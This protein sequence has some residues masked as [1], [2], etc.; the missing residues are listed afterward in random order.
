MRRL[1]FPPQYHAH[2][3]LP[4]NYA[5]KY[6]TQH[7]TQLTTNQPM[8]T[9]SGFTLFEVSISLAIVSFSVISVIMLL[10]GGLKSQ[11]MARYQIIASAKAME[12]VE[13]FNATHNA[14]PTVEVEADQPWNVH[15]N[16]KV[17]Q[18][19][20]ESKISTFRFGTYPVPLDIARRLDSEGNEIQNIL[21]EGG[22]IYYSQPVT[23]AGIQ[24]NGFPSSTQPNETQK[25]VIGIVGYPQN[26]AL[27]VLPQ[28]S[29]PY[30]A[31][32]PSPPVQVLT[33]VKPT[34]IS[35]VPVTSDNSGHTFEYKLWDSN[36]TYL[37]E[38]MD[39]EGAAKTFPYSLPAA[40]PLS[41]SG[42]PTLNEI[43]KHYHAYMTYLEDKSGP[44]RKS[45]RNN[46][47][48][49]ITPV[50]PTLKRFAEAYAQSVISWCAEYAEAD[51]PFPASGH[52]YWQGKKLVELPSPLPIKSD[53]GDILVN[54]PNI[55]F[56]AKSKR[57]IPAV[58]NTPAVNN[59]HLVVLGCRMM[60][61]VGPIMLAVGTT[62]LPVSSAVSVT[63]DQHT[64]G[65]MHDNA[66]RLG[67]FFAAAYPYNWGAPRNMQRA[68]MMDFPLIEYDLTVNPYNG[69]RLYRDSS[70]R[71]NYRTDPY[72]SLV[73]VSD[74]PN[75]PSFF[76]NIA[77]TSGPSAIKAVK[78]RPTMPHLLKNGGVGMSYYVSANH[79]SR[80][81]SD[82]Y[83]KT[84]FTSPTNS[85]L[86]AQFSAAERCRQIVFWAVDWKSYEDCETAPSAPV[87]AGRYM[88]SAPK[89][90]ISF[91]KL[92]S[93]TWLDHHQFS[94]RNPEK[95]IVFI[96]DM[97]GYPTGTATPPGRIPPGTHGLDT[98]PGLKQGVNTNDQDMEDT[99]QMRRFVGFYGADRNGNQQLDRGNVPKSVRLKATLVGRF[100]FYDRR[101]P[102]MIR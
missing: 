82:A 84:I 43:T 38:A 60:G 13:A 22:Y 9:R 31:V 37:W 95:M 89:P 59:D 66:L 102:A 36:S 11:Q 101:V 28:K 97:T 63:F 26:N 48:T 79:A 16:N 8:R 34:N 45:F 55:D 33:K 65:I 2:A 76:G 15:I 10:P 47:N 17:W 74:T 58:N 92:K 75:D 51:V 23:S 1:L 5:M 86:T 24:E 70:R 54:V 44:D 90:G 27:Q 71:D 87:D 41:V 39:V 100:N 35:G 61:H 40:S 7:T 50:D 67:N 72:S 19:D 49:P 3:I 56:P 78:W 32:Y 21:N 12:M 52:D 73:N 68:I 53:P 98:P 4:K 80:T 83:W 69:P 29:W 64:V 96:S 93:N 91:L 57:N 81:A 88:K 85:T 94:I 14:I 25:L 46:D 62:T 99:E 20:M 42:I 30:Y 77:G 6:K 18:P